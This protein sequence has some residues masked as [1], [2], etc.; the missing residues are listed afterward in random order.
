LNLQAFYAHEVGNQPGL[1]PGRNPYQFFGYILQVIKNFQ[2]PSQVENEVNLLGKGGGNLDD[3]F[4]VPN[5]TAGVGLPPE[6]RTFESQCQETM[7]L[8]KGR[9]RQICGMIV[10]TA[11]VAGRSKKSRTL[12]PKATGQSWNPLFRSKG[13][14]LRKSWSIASY[15][16]KIWRK[17]AGSRFSPFPEIQCY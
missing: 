12:P 3:T 11:G 4:P 15:W 5:E 17:P 10:P 1:M 13:L 2:K 9:G 7:A 6:S 16:E 8:F 14:Q